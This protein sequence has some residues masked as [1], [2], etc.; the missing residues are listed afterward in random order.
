MRRLKPYL[1]PLL[2][3]AAIYVLSSIPSQ[4]IPKVGAW[5]FVLKKGAHM[6]AYAVLAWLWR[7]TLPAKRAAGWLA[8]AIT[9]LYAVT[10]EFHQTLVPGRLGNAADVLVDTAGALL[11]LVVWEWHAL[12]K[13]RTAVATT[14]RT[15]HAAGD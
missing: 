14:G 3:M 9:V 15:R 8:L 5:D 12:R 11:G 1:L 7:R 13:R 2:W 6:G 4:H 10:D